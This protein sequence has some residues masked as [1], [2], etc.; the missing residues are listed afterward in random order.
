[1][2]TEPERD[3]EKTLK[4]YAE[5]RR[6]QA[7]APLS[8][9]PA[10]RGL[11]Q[12]EV[13]RL[14]PKSANQP[15]F[16]P[17]LLAMLRRR[18]VFVS[19]F[20]LLA[21]LCALLFAPPL[22][23]KRN[24]TNFAKNASVPQDILS[25]SHLSRDRSRDFNPNPPP[26][27]NV[28]SANRSDKQL[29]ASDDRK[30]ES[31]TFA[32][33]RELAY[34]TNGAT[35]DDAIADG[36]AAR[37]DAVISQAQP[38]P[39]A[40]PIGATAQS[41]TASARRDISPPA[42]P[43]VRSGG[44]TFAPAARAQGPVAHGS[45]IEFMTAAGKLGAGQKNLSNSEWGIAARTRIELP[46]STLSPAKPSAGE[47]APTFALTDATLPTG[48]STQLFARLQPQ[49]AVSGGLMLNQDKS[50]PG[51]L[52]S[53]RVEQMGDQVRIVDADGSVYLG[54][55]QKDASTSGREQTKNIFQQNGIVNV[56]ALK[57]KVT[58]NFKNQDLSNPPAQPT[59]TYFFRVTG[60]NRTLNEPV[61]FKGTLA[62]AGKAELGLNSTSNF[63]GGG[64]GS[65]GAN[66]SIA[67][68]NPV[69]LSLSQARIQGR[70]LIGGTNEFEIIAAPVKP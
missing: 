42:T 14:A 13:A 65:G 49:P 5:K 1:M 67:P 61:L 44:Q 35:L 59:Q 9:H 60:I 16:W 52:Q 70:A 34:T 66:P 46:S 54:F 17:S 19:I 64:G 27:Q 48:S 20:I 55:V 62:L 53:F 7:G 32:A 39:S 63:G 4:A 43:P 57:A 3:I 38:A 2:A 8:L 23:R 10:T 30:K 69:A 25:E 28:D 68:A 6:E 29:Q 15:G 51:I 33:D 58:D 21:G 56:G 47:T 24:E 11:L 50:S 26:S 40:A 37:K 12:R 18:V 41:T 45:G 31:G 22:S 36:L